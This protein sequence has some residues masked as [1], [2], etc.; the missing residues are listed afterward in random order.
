[1]KVNGQLHTLAALTSDEK[2]PVSNG[3]KVEWPQG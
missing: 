2:P 3:Q 1:M